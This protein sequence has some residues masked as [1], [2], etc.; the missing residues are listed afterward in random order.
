[1]HKVDLNRVLID[2][3]KVF[4][5]T[6]YMSQDILWRYVSFEKFVNMLKTTSL[7]FAKAEKFKDP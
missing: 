6:L 2:F 3:A 4:A 5:S 1:M 7:F